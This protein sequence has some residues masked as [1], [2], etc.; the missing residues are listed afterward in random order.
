MRINEKNLVT[1]ANCNSPVDKAGWLLK[2]GDL[3]KAFQKRYFVLKGNLFFYFEKQGDKE[4][5]GVIILEG[6]TVELSSSYTETF[7][8]EIA[9]QGSGCRTYVLTA[10]SQDEMEAWMKAV[11]SAG[12]EYM[13]LMVSELQ[14]QLEELNTKQDTSTLVTI[15]KRSS[16]ARAVSAAEPL[17]KFA[18][19]EEH[20]KMS[21]KSVSAVDSRFSQRASQRVPPTGR[22]NPFDTPSSGRPQVDA[23]GAAP[24]NVP[25]QQQTSN[26]YENVHDN[27]WVRQSNAKQPRSFQQ[28]H[29]EFGKLI[30]PRLSGG[31]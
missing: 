22:F 9:F 3:N 18:S 25:A 19:P 26:I 30:K 23:F 7:T 10:D 4:P 29:Q 20:S 21:E 12:Y 13:R 17:V 15:P 6:C 14:N 11:T 1:F 24:F 2:K 27:P 28:M 5:I 16:A 8:F 31:F